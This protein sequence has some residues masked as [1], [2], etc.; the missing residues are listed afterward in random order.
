MSHKLSST[1]VHEFI[2]SFEDIHKNILDDVEDVIYVS[3]PDTYELI[4]VNEAFKKNWGNNVIGKKCYKV[5]QNRDEPC[6][7]CTNDIIFNP[8]MTGAHI[9]EFQNEVNKRWYKCVDKAIDWKEGKRV[10][11]EQATDITKLKETENQLN[12]SEE[13]YR[14]LFQSMSE[15]FAYYESVF[16]DNNNPI[17][18]I[19]LD[20]NPKFEEFTGLNKD[21]I[22]GKKVT[23][24]I[25]GIENKKPNLIE[26]Y[27]LIARDGGVSSF[28]LYLE[29]FNEWYNVSVSCPRKGFFCTLFEKTTIKKKYEE[30][31][32]KTLEELK[33]S[34]KELE[35]F[36]YVASH[37]LQEPLRMVSS[38]TSL[39]K[40]KYKDVIDE[41]GNMYIDYAVDGALR[42]QALINDLLDFSRVSTKGDSFS[43]FDSNE[44]LGKA[45][46]NLRPAIEEAGAIVTNDELPNVIA[47]G[48]QLVRVFQNLISN[49][50]KFRGEANPNIHVS[51]KVINKTYQFSIS[52]N[53]IGLDTKFSDKVFAIFQRLHTRDKFPG[54]GI[55]LAICKRIIKRHH[56]RIWVESTIKK[57]S[58]FYFTI[59]IREIKN[60][61]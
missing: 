19:F 45:L 55:G 40:T 49:G 47:D 37:D 59:P 24:I 6:P 30:K 2:E 21:N 18:Y 10:R 12:E 57:G 52:D 11:F 51:C 33:L 13:K 25:P 56:G 39:L 22:I 50:I 16:D 9:W 28:E 1:T 58:T 38:F 3:T 17:D 8:K 31:I 14:T 26:K 29:Q 23:E 36:A 61:E 27:G 41:K 34:N 60:E 46:S 32:Q 44:L 54:T 42:M 48:N 35:Q 43:S 4:Y 15:G 7:F 53:G 5:L 20:V